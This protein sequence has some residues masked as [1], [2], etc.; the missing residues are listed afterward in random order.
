M[1]APEFPSNSGKPV[2]LFYSCRDWKTFFLLN[3]LKLIGKIIQAGKLHKLI[4]KSF[5]RNGILTK[6]LFNQGGSVR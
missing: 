4:I 5:T 1:P 3:T 6:T 2:D